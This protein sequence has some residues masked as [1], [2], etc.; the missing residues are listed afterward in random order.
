MESTTKERF[1]LNKIKNLISSLINKQIGE[2]LN[3]LEQKNRNE[4]NEIKRISKISKELINNLS[5]LSNESNKYNKINNK[6]SFKQNLKSSY[7]S[8]LDK[9][10]KYKK[11]LFNINSSKNQNFFLRKSYTP[12][13]NKS[14]IYPI[15]IKNRGSKISR[16]ST[17]STDIR[18]KNKSSKNINN[19]FNNNIK[20]KN[21]NF[22][23]KK[24][25]KEI[26]KT[27]IRKK[28]KNNF[29]K[30]CKTEERLNK[31]NNKFINDNYS[32]EDN[33]L[34]KLSIN[35][36]EQRISNLKL[37]TNNNSKNSEKKE[38]HINRLSLELGP[39]IETIDNEKRIYFLGDSLFK[40][41]IISRHRSIISNNNY[42]NSFLIIFEY[43]FDYL[44]MFLDSK[45][46]FNLLLANKDYLKLILRLIITKIEKKLKRIN[47]TLLDLKKNH[48]FLNLENNK[49]KP[50]EY[51]INSV[52]ALSL[53]NSISVNNFF[54]EKKINFNNKFI[55]L[56]FDLYFI[57]I[58]KKK[59][60]ISYNFNT[61]LKENYI[62]SYFQKNSNKNIGQIL[63]YEIKHIVFNNEI[64]NS[65]YNYSY[66]Y[67][68]IISPNY[69][70][71]INK[72]IALFSFLIKNILEYVGITKDL[73]NNKNINQKYH[74]YYS[75]FFINQELIK[76]LKKLKDLY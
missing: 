71:K 46:L 26:F 36:D 61:N 18:Y 65:L 45:S 30:H 17:K 62:L 73:D 20:L 50:F 10:I 16:L 52:R 32:L 22:H 43:I 47:Q 37:N 49:I 48:H 3:I 27:P 4:V 33:E 66:K 29:N 15:N 76:K 64:I 25:S 69:F 40:K 67:I 74:L 41:D 11:N 5:N 75:L 38:N 42:N 21:N 9:N 51:N 68:N 63:D 13:K 7:S 56:I 59:D 31:R 2:K 55:N 1:N 44:Y 72:N 53:L 14:C 54:N 34:E 39:L 6:I 19:S 23:V 28:N 58:G 60:I 57:S 35:F 70:Q 8:S 12:L 24:S